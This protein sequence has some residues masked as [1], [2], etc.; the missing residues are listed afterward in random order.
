MKR[1]LFVFLILVFS[2]IMLSC[3]TVVYA[4]E[5]VE[6]TSDI[7]QLVLFADDSLKNSREIMDLSGIK[8]DVYSSKLTNFDKDS[9][10]SE[11]TH[12]Y[13]FSVYTDASGKIQFLRPSEEMLILVDVSTLPKN[14]GIAISTKFYRGHITQD[15]LAVSKVNR[16]TI[17]KIESSKDDFY[18]NAYNQ[19]GTRIN[20]EYT[21][22][23]KSSLS[24]ESEKIVCME[25]RVG[26][27]ITTYED[28][29]PISRGNGLEIQCVECGEEVL[30]QESDMVKGISTIPNGLDD[31]AEFGFFRIHYN[32]STKADTTFITS[33]G[34]AFQ[35]AETSLVGGLSF[36][37]PTGY[38]EDTKYDIYVTA[39]SN[40]QDSTNSA[41]C[42]RTV[43]EDGVRKSW[44]VFYKINDLSVEPTLFQKGTAAH[45]YMHAITHTYRNNGELPLWFKEAWANWAAVRVQGIASRNVNSVNEY[46]SNTYVGFRADEN[47]YGKFLLPLYIGQNYGGD[48]TVANVVK[49]LATT[50]DVDFA[51]S[52]ALPSGVTFQSIFPSFMGYNY[53]PKYFYSTHADGW[54]RRPFISASYPMN[55][56]PNNAYGGNI[57]SYAAHYR[58]FTVPLT[59]PYHLDITIRLLNNNGSLSGKLHMNGSG[60]MATGWNFSTG[61]SLVTYSTTIGISYVKGGMSITNTGSSPTSYHITIARS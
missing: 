53:S 26:D 51:I 43:T 41:T 4:N 58:E 21:L 55:G 46:L 10:L 32:A 20:V 29:I 38:N 5:R 56:Y 16:V 59:A 31:Y 3:T 52:N 39:D 34:A 30:S 18:V 14:T 28:V 7:F 6:E 50:A 19:E 42:W 57:N 27:I 1:R 17:E 24:L 48:A 2:C 23:E 8:V 13:A 11:F 35:A 40:P 9:N 49:N 12:D 60:E 54:S 44:I 33:L 45:E 36:N 37:R 61:S 47:E 22:S 15:K 25:A